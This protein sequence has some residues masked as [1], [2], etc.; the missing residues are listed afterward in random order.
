MS[1]NSKGL[2]TSEDGSEDKFRLLTGHSSWINPICSCPKE[3]QSG[4]VYEIKT[5]PGCLGHGLE[6]R[7]PWTIRK[8]S[9]FRDPQ[10]SSPKPEVLTEIS[11]PAQLPT[12]PK[13][14]SYADKSWLSTKW[15][16]LRDMAQGGSVRAFPRKIKWFGTPSSRIGSP[17]HW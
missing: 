15:A 16:Q 5:L 2:Q 8:S 4:N 1:K 9:R 12:H 7:I 10:F 6:H 13:K 3:E 17:F 14:K 11:D